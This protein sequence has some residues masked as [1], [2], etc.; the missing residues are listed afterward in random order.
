MSQLR[1]MSNQL[2]IRK[3]IK[4]K[5]I[6]YNQ[7]KKNKEEHLT[8]MEEKRKRHQKE[9]KDL[10]DMQNYYEKQNNAFMKQIKEEYNLRKKKYDEIANQ[11]KIKR[12][13][14][15]QAYLKKM[16]I[17]EIILRNIK[18]KYEEELKNLNFKNNKKQKIYKNNIKIES[19]KAQVR[20]INFYNNFQ[21][22]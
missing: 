8:I 2:K 16:E 12:N 19:I 22:M 6:D 1:L 15:H 13:R 3:F 17:S 4:N 14:N 11:S 10:E 21:M 20:L 18:I 5:F 7:K 9:M